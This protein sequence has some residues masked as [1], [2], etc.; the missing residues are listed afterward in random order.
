M[1]SAKKYDN[2][3]KDKFE[4]M[5]TRAEI[6]HMSDDQKNKHIKDILDEQAKEKEMPITRGTTRNQRKMK[7]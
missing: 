2:S 3:W 1:I 5:Y 6:D 7:K 4:S